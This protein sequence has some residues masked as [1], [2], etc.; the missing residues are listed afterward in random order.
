MSNFALM[1]HLASRPNR[2]KEITEVLTRM[3]GKSWDGTPPGCKPLI[4]VLLHISFICVCIYVSK[5][6]DAMK[7]KVKLL[8]P[9]CI[10]PFSWICMMGFLSSQF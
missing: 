4:V 7:I 1:E 8:D 2:Q 9:Y 6:R 5:G 10:V 3:S